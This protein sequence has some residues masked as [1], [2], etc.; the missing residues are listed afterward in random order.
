MNNSR[1]ILLSLICSSFTACPALADQQAVFD[2]ESV[3]N[4]HTQPRPEKGKEPAPVVDKVVNEKT[5]MTVTL[6]PD[7]VISDSPDGKTIYNFQQ[8]Q[9]YH[10]T[11][12]KKE[13]QDADLHGVAM[14]KVN[15]YQ[16]RKMMNEVIAKAG[17]KFP[18][19]S[20]FELQGVFGLL[21]PGETP[22]DIQVV[23]E[24]KT[25][26]Y[27]QGKEE[28]ASTIESDFEL[29]DANKTA[30]RRFLVQYT[31]LHPA[32]R[33]KILAE[34]KMPSEL[35]WSFADRPLQDGVVTF[36]LKELKTVAPETITRVPPPDFKRVPPAELTSLYSA[37]DKFG[38]NPKQPPLSEAKSAAQKAVKNGN[39]L[40]A[41]LIMTDYTLS[42]GENIDEYMKELAPSLRADPATQKFM[43][44][45][46]PSNKEQAEAAIKELKSIDR[47]KLTKGH[48]IDVML[49]NIYQ[50]IDLNEA[51]KH[52]KAALAVNP[53]LAGAYHDLGEIYIGQFQ[54][55][56]GWDSFRLGKQVSP[57]HPML[58]DVEK[59]NEKL[60]TTFPHFF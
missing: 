54:T 14:F 19:S 57:T 49:G 5:T 47:S 55:T 25:T 21:M 45:I 11:P 32:V 53:L 52:M 12:A 39:P 34:K 23:R 26:K 36:K 22:A 16:N 56:T 9:V 24:G 6:G 13:Y 37:L 58:A 18:A 50:N 51:E 10:L 35:K 4:T 30:F 33:E 46:T 43:L 8:K 28:V 17:A 41:L 44:N 29:D 40:D 3:K 15:E 60:E 42:T 27:M 31:K 48:V 2:I 7:Y 38:A 59:M 20:D 1:G